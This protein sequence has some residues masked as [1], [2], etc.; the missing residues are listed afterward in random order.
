MLAVCSL[1]PWTFPL[2]PSLITL[3][4]PQYAFQAVLFSPGCW[5]THAVKHFMTPRGAFHV[6]C[7]LNG[8]RPS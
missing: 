4:I 6:N 8:I 3:S 1:L 5:W 7:E 2:S